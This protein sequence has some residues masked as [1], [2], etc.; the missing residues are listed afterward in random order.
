VTLAEFGLAV[1][2]QADQGAVDVAEAEEAEVV[3]ADANLLDGIGRVRCEGKVP[4][5]QPA[6]RRRYILTSAAVETLLATSCLQRRESLSL[7]CCRA[8]T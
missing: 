6:G 8:E 4:S 5:R 1:G 7:W 3:G 2:E